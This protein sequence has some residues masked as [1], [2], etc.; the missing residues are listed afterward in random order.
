M[1]I[2]TYLLVVLLVG[3]LAGGAYFYMIPYKQMAAE[4]E[5]LSA[6]QP[7]FDRARR[8]LAKYKEREKANSGWTEPAAERLRSGLARDISEGTAEVVV[9]GNRVVVNISEKAL[10]TP[11]SVTFAKDSPQALANLASLLKDFKD[12]EIL[13]GDATVPAPA[14]GKGRKRVP[15][16]D[17]RTLASGRTLAL[18]KYLAQNGVADE[19]LIA[20]S[21][22]AKMPD[23]GFKLK[24]EKVVIV[25]AAPAVSEA[26]PASAKPD[27]KPAVSTKTTPTPAAAS[28]IKTIP[29]STV[30]P[31]KVQ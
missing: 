3:A 24:G 10:Y 8:E 28:Q 1:K 12:R 17:A 2:V 29:I 31:K 7:E 25:I 5:K 20:A 26:L 16:K 15:A 18:V 19:T 11:N 23:R 21:Y 4:Y 14:Q 27:T 30:P 22:P 9:A 6:G 13:V